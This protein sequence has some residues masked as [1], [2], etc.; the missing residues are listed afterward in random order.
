MN[1]I[2]PHISLFK[3]A[4][5]K[6]LSIGNLN[7]QFFA[8]VY[9]NLLDQFV[10]HQLKCRYYLR[11]CD[12][13]VLL[14]RDREDLTIWKD[15]IE[16]FLVDKLQL[17]LRKSF[18]LQTVSNGIDFLGY[19]V[20]P[21]YLLIR[22]RVVNNLQVKLSEYKSLL[23]K[24]GRFYRRYL[25]DEEMLGRLHAVLS[26]YLGHFKMANSYN[27]CKSIWAKYTFL[28]QYFDLDPVEKKLV[29][30]YKHPKGFRRTYQQ[31]LSYRSRFKGDIIL[32]QVGRYFE[33]Y[34]ICDKEVAH[35]L[36]LSVLRKN[37]RRARYG[38]PINL[39][40]NY[41][42]KLFRMKMSVTLIFEK[43]RYLAGIK[44]RVPMYRYEVMNTR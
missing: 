13:L 38:F 36:G 41:L 33:F 21:D 6:G 2:L 15:K 8:N 23:V 39:M 28:D 17:E 1:R 42:R 43:E 4:E 27:L 10:K 5:N 11:Y 3:A 40:D 12:D 35:I 44:E 24:E 37:K 34:H 9:L 7:S 19:I 14:S 32:F 25:F 20:R 18:K 29:R 16:T 22:R 26:S 30:K 31:Y